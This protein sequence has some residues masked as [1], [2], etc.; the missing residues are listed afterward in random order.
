MSRVWSRNLVNEEALANL[1]LSRQ[2]QTKTKKPVAWIDE[3]FYRVVKWGSILAVRLLDFVH[4]NVQRRKV[5]GKR[6]K[7]VASLRE[8]EMLHVMF[9]ILRSC[10]LS[11]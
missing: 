11:E 5:T 10:L 6:D 4:D 2:K 7:W 3:V 8:L 9:Y 1:G